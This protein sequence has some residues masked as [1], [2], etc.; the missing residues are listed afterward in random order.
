MLVGG[1]QYFTTPCGSDCLMEMVEFR[2]DDEL[3]AVIA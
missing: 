2:V 3:E 1:V